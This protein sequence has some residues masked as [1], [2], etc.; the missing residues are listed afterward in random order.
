VRADPA[1]ALQVEQAGGKMVVLLSFF[2]SSPPL[3]LLLLSSFFFLLL[4]S[5]SFF[6]LK[7]IEILTYMNFFLVKLV[8]TLKS[9]IFKGFQ[10]QT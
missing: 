6:C 1:T 10:T 5:S 8:I 7:L 3:F 2:S 4:P 9:L